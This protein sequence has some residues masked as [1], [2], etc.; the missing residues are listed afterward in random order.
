[1]EVFSEVVKVEGGP[2]AADKEEDDEEELEEEGIVVMYRSV[3]YRV[4]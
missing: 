3:R 1:M 4:V 2:M